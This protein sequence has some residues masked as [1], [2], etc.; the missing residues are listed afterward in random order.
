MRGA[1]EEPR[2][3]ARI[4]AAY[5]LFAATT[6]PFLIYVLP[7]RMASLHPG[8]EGNPAFSEMDIAPQ[9]RIVLYASLIGFQLLFYWI[10]VQRV[11][12][13]VLEERRRDREEA[14]LVGA[15]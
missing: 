13:R 4:A 6:L 3:R 8:A 12:V 10:Y 11:R 5:C 15:L 9:M 7:R 14:Q 2:R 1:L